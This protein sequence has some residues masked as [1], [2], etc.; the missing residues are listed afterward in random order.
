MGLFSTSLLWQRVRGAWAKRTRLG[1]V[2]FYLLALEAV[3]LLGG[4]VQRR[5]QPNASGPRGWIV[6]VGIC[7]FFCLLALGFRWFRRQVMWRLRNRLIVTYGFIGVI[8]VVLLL[9][10]GLIAG[11]LFAGQFATFVVTS[12]VHSEL[13]ALE[14]VNAVTAA[15]LAAQIIRGASIAKALD[16]LP[17]QDSERSLTVWLKPASG[18]AQGFGFPAGAALTP[19]PPEP[20]ASKSR[21]IVGGTDGLYLRAWTTITAGRESLT[22]ISSLPLDKPHL[23]RIAADLGEI[24]VYPPNLKGGITPD[25]GAS[26]PERPSPDKNSAEAAARASTSGKAAEKRTVVI[27]N[28]NEV[29]VQTPGS[30]TL[31]PTLPPITAGRLPAPT[32]RFD[33]EVLFGMPFDVS[34]WA[35]GSTSAALL[36]VRTRPSLL[37]GRLFIALG[38]FANLILLLLGGVAIFFALIELVALVTGISLTR[39]MTRSVAALYSA[40]QHINSGDLSYRIKVTSRDQLAALEGS[41]NSM[42]D[43]LQKLIAEQK[44][45]QRMESELAI[46]QE[47]QAQLFPQEL[48]QLTSLE[49][50]GICRPARTVSGDYYDFLQLGQERLG[51]AVGDISGKG[52]SAALLMATIHSAVRVYEFGR[53]PSR[54]ELLAAGAAAASAAVGTASVAAA[55]AIQSPATVLSLLNRHLFHST[56]A[57]KYATLFL[58]LWDGARHR[59][60]YSNGGHLA[61]LIIGADGAARKLEVGG[62]VIGLFDQMQWDEDVVQLQPGDL[63]VAFSDGIT[64]PEN[65]FGEFGEAR[66]KEL[67]ME[68]RHE[69][70]ARIAENVIE[71]VNGWIGGAEQPDDLTLV[72]ARAR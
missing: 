54:E 25:T 13:K 69:P 5:F 24:T 33:R 51:I 34:D 40:T 27:R 21:S 42:T 62:M 1:A 63:F 19:R 60:T 47:V 22:V 35:S 26:E 18:P 23:E 12:D 66:L 57:E 43:S 71:A 56:P 15:N 70:L 39:T 11:Y 46:A 20:L 8:P 41:F 65:E 55:G 58:G 16:T 31:M 61:P 17:A 59:L 64:E 10:I 32:G 30:T 72:L 49:V 4:A 48:S 14:D 67:V 3:L 50:H 9:A 7:L 6:L 37:Y 53:M 44:E 2:T 45:K 38:E 28:G 52:I 68:H 29:L 36:R